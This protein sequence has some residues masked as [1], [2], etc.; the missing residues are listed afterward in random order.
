LNEIIARVLF[1]ENPTSSLA[2][3]NI[4]H[5]ATYDVWMNAT[6]PKGEVKPW[7]SLDGNPFTSLS[8]KNYCRYNFCHFSFV[9][10]YISSFLSIV[11]FQ[12]VTVSHGTGK[13]SP[14]ARHLLL[15]LK[16]TNVW[17][18]VEVHAIYALFFIVGYSQEGLQILKDFLDSTHNNIYDPVFLAQMVLRPLNSIIDILDGQAVIEDVYE[19]KPRQRNKQAKLTM[20]FYYEILGSM[21]Q[22]LR[23][24]GTQPEFE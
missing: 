9:T 15:N 20:L 4:P 3:I 8:Y 5:P 24:Y 10:N 1:Q 14:V 21:L 12:T 18:S 17:K 19:K 7:T 6:S 23:Q 16:Q 13:Y 2:L 11:S 22:I